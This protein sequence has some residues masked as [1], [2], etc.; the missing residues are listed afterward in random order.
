MDIKLIVLFVPNMANS[1]VNRA[2]I[3]YLMYSIPT[4]MYNL[5]TIFFN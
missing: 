1:Q 2:K 5:A 4:P 3:F